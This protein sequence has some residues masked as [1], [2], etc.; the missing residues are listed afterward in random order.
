MIDYRTIKEMARERGLHIADLCA[1]APQNDPFYVGQKA[2]RTGAQWFA[3]LW[4]RLGCKAGTHLRR[5]HYALVSQNPPVKKPN[6]KTYLN[7]ESDWDY[8]TSIS[9]WARYLGL[10]SPDAFTDRRNP[11]AILYAHFNRQHDPTPR[12]QVAGGWAE[13]QGALALPC[14]P[15]LPP[16]LPELPDFEVQG[17][18]SIEQGF[19][20]EVWVEKT[21]MNDVLVPLCKR[22]D[23]NL[24]TGAGEL[25]I[26]AVMDF[27]KRVRQANRPA[28]ILYISDFDPAGLGM[29]ISVARKI[30]FELS[31]VHE[32]GQPMPEICLHPIALTQAQVK[33]YRLPRVPVKDTD[34]RKSHFEAAYG[35]GAVELDA[36]EALH[37]DRLAHI[38]EMA[39]LKY[40]DP[41]LAA[42]ALKMRESL[43]AALAQ[44]REEELQDTAPQLEAIRQAYQALRDNYVHTQAEFVE[45]VRSFQPQLETY[46]RRLRQLQGCGL[47]LYDRLRERLAV[48]EVNLDEFALPAPALPK[49]SG[50]L[51]FDS[52]REYLRQLAA[53][54]ARR[55]GAAPHPAK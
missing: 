5:I 26:T 27:L 8:L 29:P 47:E 15:E 13:W 10:V 9:Q 20:V 24:V 14:L 7:T 32:L 52:R 25:S 38:V 31:S 51:L 33:Q 12:F 21:T 11:E 49:A 53:Y 36:L 2:Q 18:T 17:Y 35:A 37:P 3:E 45:L 46:E 22:Y 43:Q 16:A 41:T 54:K 30:E 42:R 55:N 34:R 23:A 39:L 4:Q 6:G 28:R 40:Y 50:R 1:L 48:V 19:L 44:K